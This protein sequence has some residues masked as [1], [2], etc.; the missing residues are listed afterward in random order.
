MTKARDFFRAFFLCRKASVSGRKASVSG[1]GFLLGA[2]GM[3]RLASSIVEE[4]SENP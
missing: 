2:F 4:A 1:G 3:C